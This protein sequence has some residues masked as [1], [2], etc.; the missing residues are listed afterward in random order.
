MKELFRV[1]KMV[2]CWRQTIGGVLSK[3]PVVISG[4]LGLVKTKGL[5]THFQ[6]NKGRD[7]DVPE[8]IDESTVQ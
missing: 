7:S 2:E 8:K 6:W 5:D 3:S 1:V 4:V